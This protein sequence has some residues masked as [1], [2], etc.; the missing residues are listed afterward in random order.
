MS[1]GVL[2]SGLDEAMRHL[3][4]EGVGSPAGTRHLLDAIIAHMPSMVFVKEA[5]ELRFILFNPAGEKLL[6]VESGDLIGKNDFDLFPSDQAVFFTEKDRM[7]LE[8]G[9]VLDIPCEPIDTPHGR[10]LLHTTKISMSDA[11]G[12]PALLVGISE[13]ITD[14][15][16]HEASRST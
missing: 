6:G 8:R 2:E 14:R 7:V 4:P 15:L 1:L 3:S 11:D 9:G 13:D 10:R 12:Q 5:R 16:R